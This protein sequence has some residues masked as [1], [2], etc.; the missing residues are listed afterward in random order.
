M[1]VALC[2][3]SINSRILSSS[4]EC[5][6]AAGSPQRQNVAG[7]SLVQ[8]PNTEKVMQARKWEETLLC[9]QL[10]GRWEPELFYSSWGP[11]SP[12]S[13]A[14]THTSVEVFCFQNEP[15]LLQV[16][17]N[18]VRDVYWCCLQP[19]SA[20]KSRNRFE[21]GF[22]QNLYVLCAWVPLNR[23]AFAIHFHHGTE[24]K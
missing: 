2:N 14:G 6:K 4:R 19:S 15:H 11:P 17:S 5:G 1:F 12:V 24:G 23:M 18:G 3:P 9:L 16:A 13:L 22:E 7:C 21:R 20:S 10:W 8:L